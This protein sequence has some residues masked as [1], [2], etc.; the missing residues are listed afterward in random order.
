MRSIA[1]TVLALGLVRAQGLGSL[2]VGIDHVPVVVSNLE[3]AEADFRAMGF[4]IKPGRSHADGIRNV[5]VKFTDGTEIE[6]ITAPQAVDTLTAEYR[7]KLANSEGPVF[8]GLYAPGIPALQ[9][10]LQASHIATERDE[11]LLT[12]PAGNPLH[13]IFFGGRNK[14]PT[15]KPQYF[16]HPNSATRFSAVWVDDSPEMRGLFRGLGISLTPARECR[17]IGASEVV[18]AALPEGSI[19]LVRPAT[20]NVVAARVEVRSLAT[21]ESLLKKND[22]A[23][24]RDREC[25]P[26]AL[27][28]PPS[29]AHGIWLEF[30][31]K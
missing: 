20:A 10:K 27:W 4:A 15:D 9:A 18:T 5:H 28:V 12:F 16:S 13:P 22:V 24:T 11:G 14:S 26:R 3:R 1:M 7:A 29:T 2:I 19:H 8:F 31:E 6:L 21:L 30:V 25:D 23:V 17:L